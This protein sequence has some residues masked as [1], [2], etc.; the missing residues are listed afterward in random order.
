MRL[1]DLFYSLINDKIIYLNLSDA[2]I[3]SIYKK[4][5]YFVSTGP[6][7]L[8]KNLDSM[9]GYTCVRVFTIQILQ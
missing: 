3:F 2:M 7:F 9:V 5:D 8:M 4:S 1:N 6:K